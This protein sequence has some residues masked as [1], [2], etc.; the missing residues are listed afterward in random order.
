MCRELRRWGRGW[1]DEAFNLVE[2]GEDLVEEV[3]KEERRRAH[4]HSAEFLVET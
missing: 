2:F 3:S 1:R 4:S